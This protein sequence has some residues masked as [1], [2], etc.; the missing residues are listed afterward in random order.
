LAQIQP[1]EIDKPRKTRLPLLAAKL[2]LSKRRRK[3]PILSRSSDVSM[4]KE[5]G[6]KKLCFK[7]CHA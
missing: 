7:K 6:K 5:S 1:E 3:K 2:P 4:K